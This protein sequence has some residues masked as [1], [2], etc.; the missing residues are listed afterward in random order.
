MSSWRVSVSSGAASIRPD[1]YPEES[2][3]VN[4]GMSIMFFIETSVGSLVP[5]A[6]DAGFYIMYLYKK[7]L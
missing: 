3:R 1:K 6:T 4:A 2:A 7:W 5:L